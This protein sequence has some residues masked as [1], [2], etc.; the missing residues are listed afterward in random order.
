MAMV[1]VD[2]KMYNKGG[3]SILNAYIMSELWRHFGGTCGPDC[4]FFASQFYK[5]GSA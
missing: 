5:Y 4:A 2:V 3:V 1:N